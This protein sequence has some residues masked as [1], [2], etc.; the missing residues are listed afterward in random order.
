M[1][2]RYGLPPEVIESFEDSYHGWALR[3]GGNDR[4]DL[5]GLPQHPRDRQPR[6][7]DVVDPPGQRGRD[8]RAL[9]S[10]LQPEVRGQLHPRAAPAA[11]A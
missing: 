8:V 3:H 4:R 11:S 6:R 10:R 7:P 5:R 9:P 1:A 2:A